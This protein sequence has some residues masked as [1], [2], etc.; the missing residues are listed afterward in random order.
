MGKSLSDVSVLIHFL[1]L[2]LKQGVVCI[3]LFFN[4]SPQTCL[5]VLPNKGPSSYQK[6]P[7]LE[8]SVVIILTCFEYALWDNMPNS[9]SLSEYFF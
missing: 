4:L 6:S 3:V 9:S 1:Y 7:S 2:G 5:D 8:D